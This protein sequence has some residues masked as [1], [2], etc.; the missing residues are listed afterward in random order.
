VTASRFSP[1]QRGGFW[2]PPPASHPGA[3]DGSQSVPV[4]CIGKLEG[5]NRR[6]ALLYTTPPAAS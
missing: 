5:V 2:A 6:E 1:C 4:G 3:E